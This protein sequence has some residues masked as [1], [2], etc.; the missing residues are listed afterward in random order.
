[1]GDLDVVHEPFSYLSEEG[2]FEMAGRRT[3]SMPELLGALLEGTGRGRRVFIKDTSDYR[4]D[5][6]LA[7]ER[8]YQSVVNTFMIRQPRAAVASHHAMNP[9]AT[10]DEIGFEYLHTIFEAVREATGE[11]PLV[12]D[13]D[14]LVADPEGIVRGYCERVGLEFIPDALHWQPGSQ[15]VWRRTGRWHQEVDRSSGLVAGEQ[16]HQVSPEDDPHLRRLVEHHQP[17]YDALYAHRL[18]P[19]GPVSGDQDGAPVVRSR[20]G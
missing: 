6:L 2:G 5:A 15:A 13:G 19:E 18:L 14:D 10:L 8:L 17:Y 9:D 11:V 1:R 20:S 3:T 12:I 4:Y 7:D 16:R